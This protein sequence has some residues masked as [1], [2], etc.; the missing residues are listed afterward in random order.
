MNKLGRILFG[1]IYFVVLV[2]AVVVAVAERMRSMDPSND[3]V[4][5]NLFNLTCKIFHWGPLLLANA[6]THNYSDFRSLFNIS[7]FIT[8]VMIL[9]LPLPVRA[10]YPKIWDK[11]RVTR[12]FYRFLWGVYL[13]ISGFLYFWLVLFDLIFPGGWGPAN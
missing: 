6:V 4:Y 5:G 11:Y 9:W 10:F 2:T 3:K 13:T 7:I 1:I 8:F 12:T